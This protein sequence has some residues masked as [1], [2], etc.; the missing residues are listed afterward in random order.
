MKNRYK[1]SQN[2]DLDL[3]DELNALLQQLRDEYPMVKLEA[4]IPQGH[5]IELAN[6]EV[7]SENRN[8]GITSSSSN[9]SNN[10]GNPSSRQ[11]CFYIL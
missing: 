11:C 4:W 8:Q 2:A 10:N 9:Y 3:E 7:R 6:I 1:I 5:H